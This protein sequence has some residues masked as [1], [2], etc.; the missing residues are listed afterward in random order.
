MKFPLKDQTFTFTF[1]SVKFGPE[2]DPFTPF[3]A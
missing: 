2:A 1:K 3:P